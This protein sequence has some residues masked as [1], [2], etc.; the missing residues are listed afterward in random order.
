MS[1]RNVERYSPMKVVIFVCELGVLV[2]LDLLKYGDVTIFEGVVGPSSLRNN[3]KKIS[4]VNTNV[5]QE[6]ER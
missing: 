5:I 1:A 6:R 2:P 3:R 4:Q